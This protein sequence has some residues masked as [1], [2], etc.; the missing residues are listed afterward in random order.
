ML[1]L[2]LSLS[3]ALIIVLGTT[4]TY[5][6]LQ[7]HTHQTSLETKAHETALHHAKANIFNTSRMTPSNRLLTTNKL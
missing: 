5:A 7:S 1:T 4:T 2:K 3:T 6:R